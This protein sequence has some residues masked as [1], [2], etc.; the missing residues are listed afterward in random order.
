M[1]TS[2]LSEFDLYLF[3]QGTNYHAQEMLGAHFVEQGG[4]K[5]V[6]FTVWAPNAKA[7][8][9]VGE[10]NDWNVFIH[11]MNRIDDGEIWEVFVE[12]LGEG[13]IY[14]YAI[15]PQWGGPR[16]MKADPYGFYA[17]KK[18]QTASRTYDMNHYEWQD[19][20]WQKRKEEE[21][22]YER[23]MLIYEVHA[24]SWRRT[25]EGDYL[26]YRELADQLISYVKDMNY[27][28]IEFMPLCEHPYDGSWGYQATGYFAVTS[29]YGTPDDFRYLVD[30]AHQNGIGIIMD[31]V[32]GHFCKDEQGL[33]HFD[34]K[35]LYE[36]DNEMR[37]ENWEWGT[38][39][40]DYGR[41]E[42]QSFLIS[43]ALFWFE[44]FHIDGLRIDAVANMLYLN[45]GRKD[46]EWQP[47][48]YGDTGNLEAMDF[49]KKL[50]ETIFKY[51]PQALM[52][53]EESTSWPLISKPVYMGGMG[54]N[55][56]WNMG[57][58]NDMLSYMSLDPI[59]RKWNQ[60]KITFSLMYA[61]SENFVL[62]LSHDEVVHGKCSLISKMPG[63]YWQ[64]FAGLR[65]FFGYW[66]AHPGKKLLFM[67]GEFGHFIEWNFDDSMDWHL[68]EQYPMHTKMLAYSKALNK[69]Y[70]DNKPF[71]EVDFDWNGFQ[72]IDCND[73]ENSIIA[74]VRRAEDR[75]DFI[76]C[77]HNFTPEVRHGYRIGVPTKGT[78][79]EVFNSD[80]ECYGG[81]GV[82]NAGDI[83]SEDYAFHGREQ[84]IVIT[85][86]PLATTFYRLKQQSGAGT[87]DHKVA[88]AV[89]AVAK[90]K[91]VTSKAKAAAAKKADAAPATE[92]TTP[93][94]RTA[95][96][97]TSAEKET[98]KAAPKKS[99]RTSTAKKAET[100]GKSVKKAASKK[101]PAKTVAEKKAS[102]AK[103]A[104]KS[105]KSLETSAAKTKTAS[106]TAT[107]KKPVRKAAAEVEEKPKKTRAAKS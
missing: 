103:D 53:A 99:T 107:K 44:E 14:K 82:L 61:F 96:A 105:S 21:S 64:K 27:T 16:I 83:V 39:N 86:P 17:E 79:V 48:K 42:V 106:M 38:T 33:R 56:K 36:S 70:V 46:G 29:R 54:F 9:V 52:I 20:A 95:S 74:L 41:T 71:W 11:P 87:P 43:N 67:G 85:V 37:A 51:H 35:N 19:A 88:E 31:W 58:M 94:K 15:E 8:S 62:P 3:H 77:V 91:S 72:W 30:T 23:P 57:W 7:V 12:G 50:N 1:K 65:G 78:Y 102:P 18:P 26:S 24:G 89:D 6:R 10:F 92:K 66:M 97:K 59:Y 60:D 5:G 98:K 104:T 4:K 63:D 101:P 40:F 22:S 55:Y 81:S 2:A 68:V 73:S 25:L 93:K 49:L 75:S 45:Y 69:F 100:G 34:G 84:S 28:H 32:P 90:K 80:E 47:N 13:E 76:V